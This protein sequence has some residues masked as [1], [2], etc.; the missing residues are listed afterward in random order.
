MCKGVLGCRRRE[1][2]G[3]AGIFKKT[4]AYCSRPTSIRQ[5]RRIEA[6]RSVHM[7][8][9]AVKGARRHPTRMKSAARGI[10]RH[11]AAFR[12]PFRLFFLGL[13]LLLTAKR[14][15]PFK[16]ARKKSAASPPFLLR[17]RRNAPTCAVPSW[18][19]QAAEFDGRRHQTNR[20]A[21]NPSNGRDGPNLSLYRY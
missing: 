15:A 14:T 20:A 19:A 5:K 17:L 9:A 10:D 18:H 7:P 13:L 12:E 2:G 4:L 6:T 16:K 8:P 3:K 21:L 11:A 1:R